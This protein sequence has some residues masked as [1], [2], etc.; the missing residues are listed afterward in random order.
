MRLFSQAIEIDPGYGIAHGLLSALWCR[1]WQN[2]PGDSDAALQKALALA[3]RALELDRNDSTCFSLLSSVLML[4]R[5]YDLALQHMQRAVEMNPNNQ[6]NVGDMACTLVDFGQ[7]EEALSWFKRVRE[8]DPYFDQPW[9]WRGLGRAYMGLR[10]Y[11]E[12]LGAFNHT[13][14]RQYQVAAYTA[15]CHARL[16]DTGR[17][18]A[19][20]A[21]CLA[22]KADFSVGQFVAKRQLKN[23]ADAADLAESLRMAG[24]P[25]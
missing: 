22:L 7:A 9:Y 1:K 2:E 15:G 16:G 23:P 21:E 25:G 11:E 6:W 4:R 19:C 10:R 8:I 12:A 3:N 18:M 17:A 24:L 14:S 5:S 13:P 20:A